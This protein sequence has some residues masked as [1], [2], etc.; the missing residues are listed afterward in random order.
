M[1][2]ANYLSA[3]PQ[4][5]SLRIVLVVP[6]VLQIFAAVGL[7]G[8]LSFRNGQQAVNDLAHKLIREA[9]L[10]VDQHLDTYLETPYQ[11]A[12]SNAELVESGLLNFPMPYTNSLK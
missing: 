8:Y 9:S 7:V 1:S 2:L 5:R 3:S 6:F 12:R 10:R 11:I 4:R